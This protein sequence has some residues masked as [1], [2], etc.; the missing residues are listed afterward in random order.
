MRV[1]GPVASLE[2]FG[3]GHLRTRNSSGPLVSAVGTLPYN[4][5]PIF[6]KTSDEATSKRVFVFLFAAGKDRSAILQ[7]AVQGQLAPSLL[8]EA[9]IH[10][11]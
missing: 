1:D 4:R 5:P 11:F 6:G 2:G 8:L 9:T 3:T 7:S 10:K